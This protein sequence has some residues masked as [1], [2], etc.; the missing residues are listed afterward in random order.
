M[1]RTFLGSH[2][3][4]AIM[5][6]HS[7]MTM[8]ME[9]IWLDIH[10]IG[11]QNFPVDSAKRLQ[12]SSGC[13]CGQAHALHVANSDFWHNNDTRAYLAGHTPHCLSES[14]DCSCPKAA[15]II[16]I[17]MLVLACYCL[18]L[19]LDLRAEQIGRCSGK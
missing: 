5:E 9:L 13:W 17:I 4:V 2:V 18:K 8:M 1:K 15:D 11:S 14:S 6:Q 7:G 12:T 16:L 19:A 10:P 3:S